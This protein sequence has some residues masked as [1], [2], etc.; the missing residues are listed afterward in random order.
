MGFLANQMCGL[1][2][3]SRIYCSYGVIEPA[4][5]KSELP[6]LRAEDKPIVST[7]MQQK[8]SVQMPK[9]AW[10]EWQRKNDWRAEGLL[11][12]LGLR[13]P[14]E[15]TRVQT[16]L[17]PYKMLFDLPSYCYDMHTRVGLESLKRLIGTSEAIGKFFHENRVK[18]AHRALGWQLFFVEGGRIKNELIYEPLSRMEQKVVAHQCGLSPGKWLVLRILLEEAIENGLLERIRSEVLDYFYGS[19]GAI[20]CK[21]LGL[22]F[23]P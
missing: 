5:M 21:Q 23:G 7:I 19:S 15:M 6:E 22:G 11:G 8:A 18:A 16:L 10:Q 1:S 13:L 14:L 12:F 2:N 4:A 17:P 20:N 9:N 3:R